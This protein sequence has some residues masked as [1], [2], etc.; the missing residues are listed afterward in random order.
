SETAMNVVI[1]KSAA[2]RRVGW[3]MVGLVLAALLLLVLLL[4]WW[5][6]SEPD[7]FDPVAE[8]RAGLAAGETRLV[9][10]YTTVATLKRVADTLLHKRG[11]Y[12]SNDVMPPGVLMDNMP[13][14][15]FGVLVQVRDLTR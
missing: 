8:A 2:R 4:M 10:G 12:L 1:P 5:F 9:E 11:G 14:W 7:L 3:R 6:D 15:E 13:N